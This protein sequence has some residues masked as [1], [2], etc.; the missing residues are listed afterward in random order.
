MKVEAEAADTEKYASLVRGIVTKIVDA[1]EEVE[2]TAI[3]Q[4][5]T[6]VV[7]IGVSPDDMGKVIGKAGRNIDALRSVTRAAGLVD[8]QRVHVELLETDEDEDEPEDAPEQ[9]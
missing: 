6:T 7:E 2:V 8:H 3:D 1:P 4:G 5:R 9:N